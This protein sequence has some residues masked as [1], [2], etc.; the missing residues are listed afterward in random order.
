MEDPSDE[1]L[2]AEFR[3]A[4]ASSHGRNSIDQLFRRHHRRVAAWC[5]RTTNDIEIAGDLAQEVFLK[6]FQR[7]DSFRGDSKFT[8]WL[9]TVTRNHC[10]DR[11]RSL[12]ANAEH[13]AAELPEALPDLRIEDISQRL[14]KREAEELIR[15]LMNETLDDTESQ[16]MTLHYVEQMPLQAVTRILQLTNQSGAKAYIVSARRKLA[17]ALA[18]WKINARDVRGITNVR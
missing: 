6:A 1:Q 15:R 9:Y 14:E 12:A 5:Y 7:L 13:D 10:T 16:V 18:S 8:T 3:A 11:L 2:V 4:P 17:K